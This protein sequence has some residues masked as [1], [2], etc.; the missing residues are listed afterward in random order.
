M[1]IVAWGLG[2]ALFGFSDTWQLVIEHGELHRDFSD[3]VHH[4]KQ[5]DRDSEAI[6][7]KAPRLDR[8]IC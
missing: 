6:Q 4:P 5:Q 7:A 1:Y 2:A 8:L 3:G